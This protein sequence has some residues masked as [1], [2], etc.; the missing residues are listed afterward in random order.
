MATLKE[1][2]AQKEALEQEIERTRTQNRS[3]AV[4]KVR[5]LMD[6]YG[7]SVADLSARGPGKPRGGK[8]NKVAAKYRN[9]ATGESWSG[10]GLQPK[11]LKAALGSGAKLDDFSV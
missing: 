6:E 4:S 5:A 10:R 7:L 11:W 8:G 2:I 9:K 3:D 1:L